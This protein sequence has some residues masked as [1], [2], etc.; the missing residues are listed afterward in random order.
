MYKLSYLS[1]FKNLVKKQ[2]RKH[3]KQPPQQSYLRCLC[4]IINKNITKT[5]SNKTNTKLERDNNNDWK[6]KQTNFVGLQQRKHLYSG[7]HIFKKKLEIHVNLK[8]C[9]TSDMSWDMLDDMCF[10][11][12]DTCAATKSC[13]RRHL[14]LVYVQWHNDVTL[15][16]RCAVEFYG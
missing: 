16:I 11:T 15:G 14:C 2:E 4:T 10:H 1:K 5:K 7:R 8:C 13:G 6:R 9:Q 3:L 12:S